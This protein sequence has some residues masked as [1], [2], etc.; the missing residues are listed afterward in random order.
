M[1]KKLLML[2]AMAGMCAFGMLSCRTRS[3][4]FAGESLAP[5]DAQALLS[6]EKESAKGGEEI[7]EE[8]V[9]TTQDTLYYYVAGSGEVYH[10]NAS[11]GYL[12]KSQSVLEGTLAQV[13]AAGKTRLCAACEKAKEEILPASGE[14]DTDADAQERICYYTAGGKVWHYDRNCASLANSENVLSGT[15]TQAALDGKTRPCAR[16]GD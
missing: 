9:A 5:A 8:S 11:C 13:N 4:F 10:N 16:C 3:E 7:A 15:E 2:A 1:K 6:A 14:A 12:K